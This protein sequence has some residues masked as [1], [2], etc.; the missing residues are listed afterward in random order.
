MALEYSEYSPSRLQ[1]QTYTAAPTIGV[2]VRSCTVS[3]KVSGTPS[4]VP[5]ASPKEDRMSLRTIPETVRTSI[6]LLPSAGYGPLVSLSISSRQSAASADWPPR[7]AAT[8]TP[9]TAARTER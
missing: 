4:A 7:K 8:P 9:P 1:C 6:P 2:Q 3:E 5:E